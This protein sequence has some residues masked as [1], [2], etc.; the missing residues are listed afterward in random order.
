MSLDFSLKSSEPPQVAPAPVAPAAPTFRRFGDGAATRKQLYDNVLT[1]ANTIA[2]VQNDRYTLQLSNVAYK[3]PETFTERERKKAILTGNTLQRRLSGTWNLIDNAT[4]QPVASRN[5]VIAHVPYV[6]DDG[7]MVN[8]GNKYT[9]AHQ[10][11]LRGG[12]FTRRKNNDELEAHVN[13]LPGK[14]RSH[15]IF[16]DPATGVFKFNILQA[17]IP[18]TPLLKA[19]G[20]SDTQLREQWGN[21]LFQANA[22]RDDSSALRKIYDRIVRKRDGEASPDG[23]RQAIANEFAKMELDPEVTK[24]T[25]QGDYKAPDLN[26]FLAI[27]KKL[28]ALNR[29]EIEPD[30]RDSMAYQTLLG[31]E[32]LIAER[33]S[34]DRQ[35]LRQALWKATA[36]GNLDALPSGVFTPAINA[37]L[38]GSGLASPLEEINPAEIL[39]QQTRVTRMGEGGIP[40]LDSVPDE[41]RSVQPSHLGFIDFLRTPESAKVG[42]DM[43]L[44]RTAMKGSDGKIYTQVKDLRTGKLVHKSP[45]ELAD[46]VLGFP[47]QEDELPMHFGLNKGK[48]EYVDRSKIRYELPRMENAF[49]PLANLIPAKFMAQGQRVVMGSRMYTQALPLTEPEAPLVQAGVPDEEDKSFEEIYGHHMGAVRAEKP[50]RVSKV[51]D[52]GIELTYQDGSR[53]T[54]ELRNNM[55]L[56]RKTF[57]H[58]TPAVKPGDVVKPNQLLARSNFTDAAGSV[59]MGKNLRVAYTSFEGKNFEDAVVVSQSAA[60][61]KLSSEHMYQNDVEWTDQHHRGK[62]AFIRAFPSMYD[63]KTLENFDDDG[64]VKPGSEVGHG[65]PL[66]LAVKEKE[67]SYG[68]VHRG[69]NPSLM[70][71]TVTWD[72]HLPGVVTDVEK[73]SKGVTV[74][75]KSKAELQAGDKLA[76]RYGDKGVVAEVVPD[77]RMP[78]DAEG[79]PYEILVN[80]YGII[81]RGNPAQTVEAAL[82][83]IAARTGKPYKLK[84]FD[85]KEELIKFAARELRKH[86][87]TS[88]EPIYDQSN[89]LKIPGIQTGVRFFMKLHHTSE[90]K[91][92]ARSIGAYTSEGAPA[93]GGEDGAKRVGMLDLGALLAHGVPHVIRDVKLVRGQA[94]PRH[95]SQIAAGFNPPTPDIPPAYQKFVNLLKAGGINAVREGTRT[96][97]M[98]M[99]DKAVNELAGA[100]ELEN[101][102]TVDWKGAMRPKKGGLFDEALTG[103]HGGT[104]WSKITFHEPMP[105]PVME[106][107]IRRVLGL[108]EKKFREVLAG[109]EDIG[110][111]RGPGAIVTALQNVDVDRELGRA[112]EEIKSGKASARDAA[113]RRLRYLKDTQRLGIHPSEWV[114]SAAPVLPPMF[115]PVTT[116]GA[117]KLPL[118]A[119]PNYLYKEMFEANQNLKELSG[120]VDDT[121]D[122]RLNLYDTFKAVTGLGSPTHPKNVERNVKG[123]LRHIFGPSPKFGMIQRKLLSTTTDLVGRAVITPNPDFDMDTVGIPEDKAWK[124]YEP[125]IV[126]HL[127]RRGMGRVQAAR[128]VDA[129]TP[130]AKQALQAQ[131]ERGPIIINRAPVLH[132]YGMMAFQPKLV[133]GHTMQVS[134]LIVGG[135][136]ADFDGDAMQYHVPST[137]EAAKEAAEK[138]LPSKNL[139]SDASFRVQHKPSQEYQ[140]GIYEASARINKQNRSRTFPTY[141]DAVRAYARGDIG[142]DSEVEILDR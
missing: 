138:M 1:A 85:T 7:T 100:R 96:H 69:R 68:Q 106:E 13:F 29:G 66:I 93:K 113:V 86:G 80:P 118:V 6:A 41:S 20:A 111:K 133:K 72:H 124:I 15:K 64:I 131:L 52:D 89:G 24:H 107:P 115:R 129:R 2:P 87:L 27:T 30:D 90:S 121:A 32:D 88:R 21:E 37:S 22:T 98:A 105:N 126:R 70:D 43:R 59:A 51:D 92:Q 104:R 54:F 97:L 99:T 116:M 117:K 101:V 119:D 95:W 134:P 63:R 103:G 130:D 127:V 84:D 75:V 5:M 94:N 77:E 141:A 9:M 8:R 109:R 122:E 42:V 135:F 56:N 19:L 120:M 73:T 11:R 128:A 48:L 16:L 39:D 142:V 136:N 108:T 132:R 34:R 14:G 40:S 82:G 46:D 140:G 12:V 55:P 53:Q 26:T 4:Q 33:I 60:R 102:E 57:W 79:R 50:G 125:Y 49:S 62:H 81:S 47:G 25:L 44:A 110:G 83:K 18:L 65:Q 3:D 61:D 139:F 137:E 45:Q 28:V 58:Q 67:R 114:M 71:D 78:T 112:R 36:K 123:V 23:M 35:S 10:M 31:P 91:G 74:V 38:M 76:G 17:N